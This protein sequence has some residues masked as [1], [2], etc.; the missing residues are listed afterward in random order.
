[1]ILRERWHGEDRWICPVQ[2]EE[3]RRQARVGLFIT[4]P[5]AC[6]R[7]IFTSRSGKQFMD[8]CLA[9]FALRNGDVEAR[10]GP[11]LYHTLSFTR[12]AAMEEQRM[13]IHHSSALN[14]EKRV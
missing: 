8:Q 2:S 5:Q 4:E 3:Q 7:H 14:G 11:C 10:A 6:F 12:A 13:T 1:M 9:K